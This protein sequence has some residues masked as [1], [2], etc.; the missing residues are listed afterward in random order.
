MHGMQMLQK[1]WKT[2][3]TI[4]LLLFVL[5]I[6]RLQPIWF[7]DNLGRVRVAGCTWLTKAALSGML[8]SLVCV[9]ICF[10]VHSIPFHC[11][12]SV[13]AGAGWSGGGCGRVFGSAV[14]P[15]ECIVRLR[16]AV[17]GRFAAVFRFPPF[18]PVTEF[19]GTF[20]RACSSR[21]R[22]LEAHV[23]LLARIFRESWWTL[24]GAAHQI[25]HISAGW[26]LLHRRQGS[27]LMDVPT[28]HHPMIPEGRGP[29]RYIPRN[30]GWYECT[31]I[32]ILLLP[33]VK[34][35]AEERRIRPH[36][37]HASTTWTTARRRCMLCESAACRL[38]ASACLCDTASCFTRRDRSRF[39]QW[40]CKR[41]YNDC[42]PVH[43]LAAC[44]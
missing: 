26:R 43:S 27:I 39:T 10:F 41:R 25:G 8:A 5:I 35:R 42:S 31:G 34:Q 23:A 30:I 24:L 44:S 36:C 37:V 1:K 29:Y 7:I 15:M 19:E 9:S 21:R 13:R 6:H 17:G 28:L 20:A 40:R 33:S 12:L 16:L 22:R 18:L 3:L 11:P 4:L 14:E 38:H 32:R 2:L